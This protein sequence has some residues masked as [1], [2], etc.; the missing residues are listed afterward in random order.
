M[1]PPP[2]VPRCRGIRALLFAAIAASIAPAGAC[3]QRAPAARIA[4]DTAY[5]A[6]IA[7]LSEPGGYFDSDNLIT[8]ERSLLHALRAMRRHGV[9]GGAYVGVGPDQN[10]SYIAHLRPEVAYILDIR[11]DN[12]LQH[13]LFRAM[14]ETA[15]HR[16]D[17]LALLF[18]RPLPAPRSLA[19][20]PVEQVVAWIDSTPAVRDG[21]AAARA[22][23]M[24]RIG[25]YGVSLDSA[26]RAGIERIHLAFVAAGMDL[27]FTSFWRGPRPYYPSYREMLLERDLDG[28]QAHF[29]AS[30][31]LFQVVKRLAAGGRI[32][33]VVGNFAGPHALVA[34]GNDIRRRGLRVSAFYTS[35]VEF[36][37]VRDG[38]F[39]RFA[40]N[41]AALPADARSVIVRSYFSGGFRP[42]LPQTVAG[43]ASTQLVQ[44]LRYFIE[45]AR[46]GGFPT[47]AE[48]VGK[49]IL[50]P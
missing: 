14:F 18:G 6:A 15:E 39:P 25:G 22:A 50:E 47:Y 12:L 11:R 46:R 20:A 28:R 41:A 13:L 45:E 3:G 16:A 23:L 19:A 30:E 34:I 38:S 42:P 31:E 21:G 43:Y 5:A 7:R 37:L 24:R 2:I 9:T 17:W 35:N 8:N 26:D 29:L 10:F 1:H 36:Y 27:K 33:P 49:G 44:P 40:E 32:I 48:I 4:A